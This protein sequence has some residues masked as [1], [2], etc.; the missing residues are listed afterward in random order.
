MPR[1]LVLSL[2][3]SAM[4]LIASSATHAAETLKLKG[5]GSWEMLSQ[6]RDFEKP[7]WTEQLAKDTDG[8]IEVDYTAFNSAGLK[9]P[10]IVRLMK[11]GAIDLGTTVLSYI[12]AEDPITEGVDLAGTLT[13]AAIARKVVS[14]YQPA[15]AA[16]FDKKYDIR[17]LGLWP[18][19]AQMLFCK[20]KITSLDSVKGKK[21]RVSL[22]TTSDLLESYGAVT[23]N[24]PF[25]ETYKK[26]KEGA[27]DCLVT[28]TLPGHAAKF[29]EVTTHLYALPLG[30]AMMMAGISNTAWDKIQ[31]DDQ[32]RMTQG[33]KQL[34][35]HLWNAAETQTEQG[36]L[37]NAGKPGCTLA[38]KGNMTIVTPTEADRARLREIV[39]KTVVR[40]WG[41][42]CGAEC[43]KV[44]RNDVGK[45]I[46]LGSAR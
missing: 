30:W 27:V 11:L 33:V 41:E 28:G 32:A 19:P 20:N 22:R 7:F 21:V 37:C 8:R 9:G 24:I 10:E 2:L 43:E 17:V 34:A 45:L 26:L 3:L 42:R 18:Y 46:G 13:D 4:A 29:Y 39:S 31:P 6:F 16:H 12:S 25:D 5:H 35:D 38:H 23:V 40:R 15:L 36:I 14:V 44:W 1:A